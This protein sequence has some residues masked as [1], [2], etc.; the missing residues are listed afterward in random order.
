M[1]GEQASEKE[2][3]D[4]RLFMI[5]EEDVLVHLTTMAQYYIYIPICISV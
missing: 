2:M 1:L 3:L 4:T 5:H